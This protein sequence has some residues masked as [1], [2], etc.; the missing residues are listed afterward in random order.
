MRVNLTKT[1]GVKRLDWATPGKA[2]REAR[3]QARTAEMR[4]R[5]RG[6]NRGGK[7][8]SP[9]WGSA[10]GDVIEVL[11]YLLYPGRGGP[12]RVFGYLNSSA[13]TRITSAV[14][15]RQSMAMVIATRIQDDF[16]SNRPHLLCVGTAR[17]SF[18]AARG[19][20]VRSSGPIL[21]QRFPHTQKKRD[22]STVVIL[23]GSVRTVT[24]V[25]HPNGRV[26]R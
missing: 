21:R 26:F 18:Q 5:R 22:H 19:P 17:R 7:A 12:S 8:G 10:M 9:I 4:N 13:R 11:L 24:R 2:G 14:T 15:N 1:S 3:E 16:S 20:T 6:R 23:T 25:G